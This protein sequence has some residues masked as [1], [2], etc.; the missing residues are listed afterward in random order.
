MS[1]A[2]PR[3]FVTPEF[4]PLVRALELYVPA[5]GPGGAVLSVHHRGQLVAN[6]AVGTRDRDGALMQPETLVMGLS[7]V[8]GVTATLLHIIADRGII[9]LAAPVA[10]YWPEFAQAGKRDITVHELVSHRAGLYMLPDTIERIEDIYDWERMVGA[11]ARAK[12]AHAPGRD[13]GYHAWTF[14]W[15]VGE[16]LQRATGALFSDLLREC[17][18]KPLALTGCYIGLPDSEHHRVAKIIQVQTGEPP[19]SG[20][21]RSLVSQAPALAQAGIGMGIGL[22]S[23]VTRALGLRFDPA[24]AMRAMAPPGLSQLNL[25]APAFLRAVIPSVN[26]V[27]DAI[28]LSR[29]YA[30]LANGGELGGVRLLSRAAIDRARADQSVGLGRVIP[31]PL[32]VK[33]GYHRP[34]SLGVRVSMFGR[35]RDLGIA[36][37]DAFGHFGLGGSG[38]WADPERELSVAVVTNCF[39]GRLPADLRTVGV[40]T[41]ANFAADRRSPSS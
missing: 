12:P 23:K 9:D 6:L 18:A 7:T 1:A 19:R 16:L 28:S 11:L 29:I 40:C 21:A 26:G 4:A 35:D 3:G 32:R 22:G 30:A 15:L 14:G 2:K 5:R 27:F 10:R 33:M 38:A 8:K 39:V 37:A 17:I 25:N 36:S 34:V 13:L 20:A 31:F 24:Q 41:A